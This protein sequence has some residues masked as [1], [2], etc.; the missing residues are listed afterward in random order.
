MWMYVKFP[1]LQKYSFT[2]KNFFPLKID[3]SHTLPHRLPLLS[4][5]VFETNQEQECRLTILCGYPHP[6]SFQ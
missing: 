6:L 2:G 5:M 3:K 1:E 4:S